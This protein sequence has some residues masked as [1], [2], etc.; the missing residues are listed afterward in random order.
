MILLCN[1][2]NIPGTLLDL[3]E[4]WFL[5]KMVQKRIQAHK[6]HSMSYALWGWFPVL[7]PCIV[8]SSWETGT[9]LEKRLFLT[10]LAVLLLILF[11]ALKPF[12]TLNCIYTNPV[13][14]D[15]SRALTHAALLQW[16]PDSILLLSEFQ[17]HI[18]HCSSAFTLYLC[19]CVCMP[20]F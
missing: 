20:T 13:T 10:S 19:V 14:A 5:P 3:T 4:P 1:N 11:S 7:A 9:Y 18:P 8:E 15:S 12:I 16:T 2:C 6:V 17:H